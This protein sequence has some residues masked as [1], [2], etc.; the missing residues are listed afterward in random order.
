MLWLNDRLDWHQHRLW[1]SRCVETV[2]GTSSLPRA[3]EALDSHLESAS[4]YLTA[5][6]QVI[7]FLL[8]T[9]VALLTHYQPLG[10]MESDFILYMADADS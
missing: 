1:R 5:G 9:V 7:V 4:R 6:M 8:F 2:A 10:M 3:V